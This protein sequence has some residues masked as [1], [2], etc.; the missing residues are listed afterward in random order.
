MQLV[1]GRVGRAHGI[2]GDVSVEVRTDDPDLR[3]A[4]GAR[5]LTDP[6]GRGPL[7][8][9]D[10]RWH[11]GRLLVRFKGVDDRT[12]A[13]GLHGTMLVVDVDE[14]AR[15]DDPDEFY[16]HQLVGL[17][18]LSS[19]GAHVGEVTDVLHLPAQDVL[20]IKR[21]D[22]AEVLVPFVKE[23]VPS[24]DLDGRVVTVESRP[25]LLDPEA[26]DEG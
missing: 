6:P 7:E 11:S 21:D 25:G 22:G 2:K 3:F 12:S 26:A 17:R 10:A 15:P 13:E 18:V 9:V 19:A 24:V 4:D 5:L 23:L 16:D 20:A 14:T 8:V 1:V